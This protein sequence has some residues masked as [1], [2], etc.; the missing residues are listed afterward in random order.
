MFYD[1]ACKAG[2]QIDCSAPGNWLCG[3]ELPLT[4]A[5]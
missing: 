4:D 2:F 1:D 5:D 3:L